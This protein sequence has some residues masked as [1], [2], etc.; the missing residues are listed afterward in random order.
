[1]LPDSIPIHEIGIELDQNLAS[2][3]LLLSQC[4]GRD[5]VITI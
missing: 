4:I 3:L 5:L 1:M 2:V